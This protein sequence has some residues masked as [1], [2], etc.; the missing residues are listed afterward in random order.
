M[1]TIH[2]YPAILEH[3]LAELQ[4]KVDIV[5]PYCT[6]VHLD[7]M[8]GEFVANT[9]VND[10]AEVAEVNWGNLRVS[11]HLMIKNPIFYLKKWAFPQVDSI[12]IHLE[13]SSNLTEEIK[14]IK[15]LGKQP[16][17][18][19][20]PHTPTYAITEYL[21]EL[22]GVMIMAVEPGFSTQAFNADVLN[23]IAYLHALKPALPIMVDGGVNGTTKDAILKAGATIL[24][25][26][27]YIF[28]ATDVGQA[29]QHLQN[30]TQ[31]STHA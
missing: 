10:P 20:N 7:V 17:V 22:A 14:L 31:I 30:I 24:C 6:T 8:D 27:S 1:S 23:K 4:H 5:K 25:A 19:I 21:D 15:Q 3:D 16:V 2:V 13:A 11:L 29:I 28:K 18:A 26:N 9:T 12:V